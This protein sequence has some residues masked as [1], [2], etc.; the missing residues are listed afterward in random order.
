MRY[1]LS[2]RTTKYKTYYLVYSITKKVLCK[3]KFFSLRYTSLLLDYGKMRTNRIAADRVQNFA[4]REQSPLLPSRLL[5]AVL[6]EAR[7]V[8]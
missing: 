6:A 2:R 7:F 8:L 3:H 4:S 1:Y 5:N